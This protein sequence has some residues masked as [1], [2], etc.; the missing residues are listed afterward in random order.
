MTCKLHVATLK[1]RSNV[2][3][4]CLP[5]PNIPFACSASAISFGLTCWFASFKMEIKSLA[6]LAFP[7]VK[8]VYEVPVRSDLAVLPMR[9]T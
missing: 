2:Q 1:Q 8:K 4:A 6:C 3:Q 7:T 5:L 9:C